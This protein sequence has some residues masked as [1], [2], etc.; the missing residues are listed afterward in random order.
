MI[1]KQNLHT[2]KHYCDG[3][4]TLEEFVLQA[5]DFGLDTLGFSC[6]AYQYFSPIH[7]ISEENTV[8]YKAEIAELKRSMRAKSGFLQGL[9]LICSHALMSAIL[10]IPSVH[11]TL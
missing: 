11:P 4:G 9:K 3:M 10:I 7:T 1:Y 8:K 2:H 6:H 5:I